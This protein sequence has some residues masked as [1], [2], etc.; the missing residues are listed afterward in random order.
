MG[1]TRVR[2]FNM[3][4][5]YHQCPE[6]V[7]SMHE[8]VYPS[9]GAVTLPASGL[10]S[11]Q[12]RI[13]TPR[14][15][16][17]PRPATNHR[18]QAFP[19]VVY[20]LLGI[21]FLTVAGINLVGTNDPMM[22][23]VF[24]V[25]GLPFTAIGIPLFITGLLGYLRTKAALRGEVIEGQIMSI[26]LNRKVNV[27]G[28][29]PWRIRCRIYLPDSEDPIDV[30]SSTWEHDPTPLLHKTRLETLPVYVDLKDPNKRHYVDDSAIRDQE[31][32]ALGAPQ[33][34]LPPVPDR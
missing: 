29:H 20:S 16:P 5:G 27:R 34:H 13:A 32:K 33:Y 1:G 2:G 18:V 9:P 26:D 25:I 4:S 3:T 22:F 15:P 14:K 31:S 23:G 7:A 28:V 24:G 8:P 30:F 12:P 19:G 21:L 17:K 11:V 10:V 6:N